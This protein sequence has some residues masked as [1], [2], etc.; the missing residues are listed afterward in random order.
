MVAEDFDLRLGFVGVCGVPKVCGAPMKRVGEMVH[1]K[2]VQ[3]S[4]IV[5][6]GDDVDTVGDECSGESRKGQFLGGE[7]LGRVC[8]RC[9]F[10]AS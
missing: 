6:I 2:D 10:F 4:R 8:E 1:S 3:K 9:A 5:R 7:C